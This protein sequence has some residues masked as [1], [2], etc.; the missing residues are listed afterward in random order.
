MEIREAVD[1]ERL[2]RRTDFLA[3]KKGA[4]VHGRAFVLQAIRRPE[5]KL[6]STTNAPARFGITVTKRVGNSVVRNRIKRRLREVIR[7]HSAKHAQNGTDYVLI[8][9]HSARQ[10][11]FFE[12]V[13][14][15]HT[16]LK[17]IRQINRSR[18]H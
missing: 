15:F 16:G 13:D 18:N 10:A 6:S 8:A 9:R 2:K 5:T 3:T 11:P 1:L 4:R 12:L 7:L 14:E 17:Q